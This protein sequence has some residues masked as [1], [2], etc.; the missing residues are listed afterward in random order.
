MEDSLQPKPVWDMDEIKPGSLAVF[1]PSTGPGP[2]ISL[3]ISSIYDLYFIKI[4]DY[5]KIPMYV[6]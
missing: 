2:S 3:K 5:T 6:W 4:N 1:F